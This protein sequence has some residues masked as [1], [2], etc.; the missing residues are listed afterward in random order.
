MDVAFQLLDVF[1]DAPFE[2]N[3]LC[4]VLDTPADLDA[5]GML[6]VAREIGF[7]ET[8]VRDRRS[9]RWVRRPDLHAGC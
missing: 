7:S 6:A 1:A 2:G 9:P 3:Q 5:D 8:H 4:V